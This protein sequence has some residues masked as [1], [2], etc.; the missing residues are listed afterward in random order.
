MIVYQHL[1]FV[2]DRVPRSLRFDTRLFV[3]KSPPFRFG[4]RLF[5][6]GISIDLAQLPK[7]FYEDLNDYVPSFS[8]VCSRLI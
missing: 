8:D 3:E 4:I 1:D 2:Q 7:L 5:R 6:F